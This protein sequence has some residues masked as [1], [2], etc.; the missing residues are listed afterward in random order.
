MSGLTR[1]RGF[2]PPY[3]TVSVVNQTLLPPCHKR[4]DTAPHFHNNRHRHLGYYRV[5]PVLPNCLMRSKTVVHKQPQQ[6]Q[7][8][9]QVIK[10]QMPPIRQRPRVSEH[11]KGPETGPEQP[12]QKRRP[13]YFSFPR[14]SMGTRQSCPYSIPQELPEWISRPVPDRSINPVVLFPSPAMDQ[15]DGSA[16]FPEKRECL[17]VFLPSCLPF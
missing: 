2:L 5:Q 3:S 6:V 4:P 1:G 9:V 17:P 15:N 13:N 10:N 16:I 7:L 14:W 11:Q 8:T 12:D